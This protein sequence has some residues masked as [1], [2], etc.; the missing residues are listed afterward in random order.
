MPKKNPVPTY[1]RHSRKDQAVIDVYRHDGKRTKVY[2]PGPYDSPESKAEYARLVALMQAHGGRLPLHPGE[3][4]PGDLTID[5]VVLL[6]L[7][8]KV[9]VDY[10]PAEQE[11]NLHALKPLTRLYGWAL[12]R[13]F[14][15]K[16]LGV[17]RDAMVSGSWMNDKERE[18]A[19]KHGRPIGWARKTI[20]NHTSR[21]RSMFRWAVLEKIVPAS[22]VVDIDCL[23]T[24]KRGRGGARDTEPIAPVEIETVKETLP[25]LIRNEG[26]FRR[27]L[28]CLSISSTR[29]TWRRLCGANLGGDAKAD[30][31]A[32][33]AGNPGAVA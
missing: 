27:Q 9:D 5:E 24:L 2:L 10:T 12:A 26:R 4:A 11:S 1:R 31:V 17:V 16:T 8:K 25:H 15:A 32:R 22:V 28:T 19:E 30:D 3:R 7:E 33:R 6:F 29:L 21:I 13:D 20:N 18:R 23:P 14:D